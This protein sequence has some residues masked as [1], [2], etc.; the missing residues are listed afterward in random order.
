MG[1]ERYVVGIGNLRVLITEDEG[2]WLAQGLEIDYFA[3][4]ESMETAQ[5]AFQSGL[6]ATI[7]EHLKIHGHIKNLLTVAPE[8][9]WQGFYSSRSCH[10][11]SQVHVFEVGPF[12]GISFLAEQAA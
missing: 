7:R 8:E 2:A 4:G 12:S 5:A 10:V 9:V 3:E 1:R 6:L 11:H